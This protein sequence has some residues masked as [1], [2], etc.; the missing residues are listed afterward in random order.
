MER[1]L[2]EL[3]IARR[4]LLDGLVMTVEVSAVSI[5]VGSA[6]GLFVGVALA[7]GPRALRWPTRFYVDVVRGT[8]VLVLILATYYMPSGLGLSPGPI[9]AGIIALIVF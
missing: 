4:A 7:F 2:A 6:I 3:W 1:F 8:P 5:V 9:T